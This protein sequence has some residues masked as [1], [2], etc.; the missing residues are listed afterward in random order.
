MTQVLEQAT[1]ARKEGNWSLLN[2]YL[3][4]LPLAK[5]AKQTDAAWQDLNQSDLET[6]VNLALDVLES[7][8]FQERWE[9]AKVFPSL[10]EI[11][12]SQGDI[13]KVLAPLIEI[14]Q[15]EEA[16]LEVR[17]FTGRILGG[18]NHPTAIAA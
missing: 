2:Q 5:K 10:A 16:E 13:Q 8:D 6:V 18:F 17:W 4:Q 15:D 9:V 7:G 3:Q 14:L 11:L 12:L 1:A